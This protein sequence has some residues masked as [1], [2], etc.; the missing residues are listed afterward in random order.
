MLQMGYYSLMSSKRIWNTNEGVAFCQIHN[1]RLKRQIMGI[2]NRKNKTHQLLVQ[3]AYRKYILPD[4]TLC[5]LAGNYNRRDKLSASS[6]L[7]M[8]AAGSFKIVAT[9]Y[10][11]AWCHNPNQIRHFQHCGTSSLLKICYPPA[12]I[13]HC[14]PYCIREISSGVSTPST[15]HT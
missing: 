10:R 7:K 3:F 2:R 8:K 5:S 12:H 13:E 11:A 9:T 14:L 15:Q 6:T 4:Y 1:K